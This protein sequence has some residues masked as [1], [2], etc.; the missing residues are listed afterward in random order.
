MLAAVFR[1]LCPFFICIPS[2][3]GE[4]GVQKEGEAQ[5]SSG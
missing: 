1:E 3:V 5:A 4:N 2:Y